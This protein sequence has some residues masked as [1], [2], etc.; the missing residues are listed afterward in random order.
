M[1]TLLLDVMS[2][3]ATPLVT[4]VHGEQR[5]G[6]DLVDVYYDLVAVDSTS[7]SVRL[8]VSADGGSNWSVP[9]INV[10]QSVGTGVSPGRGKHILWNA[11]ADWDGHVSQ[12]VRF[13]VTAVTSQD[14][15]PQGIGINFTGNVWFL[16]PTDQPGVVAGANWNNVSGASGTK[17]HLQDALGAST[18]SQLSFV[19]TAPWAA[20]LATRTPNAATNLLYSGGLVGNDTISEVKVS[21][22]GIP[23]DSYDVYVYASQEGP[24]TNTLSI[25]DGTTTFYYCSFGENYNDTTA[26][27][28]TTGTDVSN[29]TRGAPQYQVF[30]GLTKSSFSLTTGGSLNGILSNNVYGLQIVSRDKSD[31]MALIPARCFQMGNT[32]GIGNEM[33]SRHTRC[34]WSPLLVRSQNPPID[35]D[36]HALHPDETTVPQ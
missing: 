10:S 36:L 11:G 28:Q 20:F 24:L 16:Q 34:G 27:I 21:I 31:S 17:V 3:T 30:R 25:S 23:Y 26:L 33:N 4:N 6:T 18:N 13:K 1:V 32:L 29:P 35:F 22:T 12:N 14:A 15:N 19:S 7:V 9:V 8:E 2:A 5:P